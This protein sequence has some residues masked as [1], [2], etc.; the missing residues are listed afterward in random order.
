MNNLRYPRTAEA[1]MKKGRRWCDIW[2][3]IL[4]VAIRAAYRRSLIGTCGFV[5]TRE[6][7]DL[8]IGGGYSRRLAVERANVKRPPVAGAVFCMSTSIHHAEVPPPI[9]PPFLH[10]SIFRRLIRVRFASS[11]VCTT[12]CYVLLLVYSS[13]LVLR[14]LIA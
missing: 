2:F 3:S 4:R 5:Y 14:G 7:V 11:S 13:A 12:R 8:I 9:V 1:G 10:S 6:A